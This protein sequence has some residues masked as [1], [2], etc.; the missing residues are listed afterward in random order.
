MNNHLL[1]TAAH[2]L[3]LC[4][5]LSSLSS[6]V[7]HQ[8][9]LNFQGEE[10][11]LNQPEDILNAVNLRIQPEDLLRITVHSYDEEAAAPFNIE[12]TEQGGGNRM[13]MGGG[14]QNSQGLELFMGYFVDREGMIDFPVLGR[15]PVAGLTLEE[16]KFKLLD[17][18]QTY[19]KDAVVNMRFLNFKVTVLGEVN[20]PGT[21][22]LTNKRVTV[23]E[24]LGMAGDLTPYANR[25]NILIIREHEGK[26]VYERLNLQDNSVFVSPYFYLMQ[27]DVVYIEPLRA[28]TATT[29]DL[30]QRIIAY[31]S[32]GLSV[33]TL[34]L[35]LSSR[36]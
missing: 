17:M 15:V 8:Q 28:R 22:R 33:L 20:L 4:L 29:A 10:L 5:L 16:A 26:R 23:L 34:V 3:L 32:A 13:M 31:T 11:P 7:T 1:R 24:A 9:L 27:N 25:A 18:L 21:V 19:L 6:C 35:T 14:G 2:G 36:R 30:F 12:G